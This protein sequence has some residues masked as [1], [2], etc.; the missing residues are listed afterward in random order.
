METEHL[1]RMEGIDISGGYVGHRRR[2]GPEPHGDYEKLHAFRCEERAV[3]RR[4][5]NAD[6]AVH[7]HQGH[8]FQRRT[9]QPHDQEPLRLANSEAAEPAAADEGGERR[10]RAQHSHGDVGYR[11]RCDEPAASF[12]A[13]ARTPE[14]RAKNEQVA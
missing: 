14:H 10:R 4:V 12:V 3:F 7:S 9:G 2:G 6:V 5:E 13:Q 1:T 11:Q 8:G